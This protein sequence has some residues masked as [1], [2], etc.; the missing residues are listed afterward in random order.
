MN[1]AQYRRLVAIERVI[2]HIGPPADLPPASETSDADA[3]EQ[4]RRLIHASAFVPRPEPLSAEQ[5]A[6]VLRLWRELT[7]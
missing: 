6:G 3:V 4:C 5:E 1:G 7:T 2:A